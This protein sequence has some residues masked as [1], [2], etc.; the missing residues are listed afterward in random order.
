MA[1][2]QLFTVVAA[3][4]AVSPLTAWAEKADS[5]DEKTGLALGEHFELVRA[6]CTGCHSPRLI[7]QARLSKDDWNATLRWM[8]A[9]QGLWSFPPA[10]ENQILD[11][12][13]RHYGPSDA[14]PRRRPLPPGLRPPTREALA[15]MEST[16]RTLENAKNLKK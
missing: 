13:V 1:C 3:L 10:T 14:V 16:G 6:S 8:Q 2:W 15:R 7:T 12:L 5:V 9:T 4:L 11:Y